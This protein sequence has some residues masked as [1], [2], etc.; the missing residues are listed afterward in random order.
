MKR[1]YVTAHHLKQQQLNKKS[2][3]VGKNAKMPTRKSPRL[4]KQQQNNEASAT[5]DCASAK[6]KLVLPEP[7]HEDEC[8]GDN[9]LEV[10]VR[11]ILSTFKFLSSLHVL[12]F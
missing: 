8:M 10:I 5:K 1:M 9:Q 12:E 2:V 4:N 6:R 7:S 3:Q 11:N